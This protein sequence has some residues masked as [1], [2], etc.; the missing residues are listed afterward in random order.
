MKKMIGVEKLLFF[1]DEI[2][3]HDMENLFI[4]TRFA[5]LRK[6][7]VLYNLYEKSVILNALIHLNLCAKCSFYYDS[8]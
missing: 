8:I 1:L 5:L 2:Y 4:N 6:V 3:S 7:F